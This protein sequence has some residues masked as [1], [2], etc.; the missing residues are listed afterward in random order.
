MKKI[1]LLIAV[2]LPIVT[3]AQPRGGFGGPQGGPQGNPQVA[4]AKEALAKAKADSENAKKATKANTW[5]KLYDAAMAAYELPIANLIEGATREQISLYLK[6]QRVLSSGET[7]NGAEGVYSVDTYAD[8]KLYYTP[9]GTLAFWIANQVDENALD[10]AY[11]AIIKSA[12]LN[13]KGKDLVKKVQKINTAYNTEATFQYLYGDYAKATELFEKATNSTKNPVLNGIDSLATYYTGVMASL[14]G[15]NQKAIKFLTECANIGYTNN[16]SL[17]PNLANVYV[18]LGDKEAAK[19]TLED[20]FI[21]YPENQGIL[22]GLINFYVESGSDTDKLFDLL[23]TAQANEPNN[24]SLF[25][26]EGDI[27]KKLGNKEEAAKFFHKA[28]EVDPN[29]VY[30]IL[31]VGILYYEEAVEIQAKAAEEVDDAKYAV[32]MDEFN[33]NLKQAIDPLE[34]SFA[35]AQE[36]DVKMAIAEYLKNIYFRYR[37]ESPEYMAAYEKYN[38]FIKGE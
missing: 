29:Y 8:K 37:T 31:N 33:A 28:T 26:V 7:Y 35:L 38:N 24:P 1:L 25:Y 4:A 21:K 23:H 2:A 6:G 11:T 22:V 16:G 14:A 19:K 13:P 36:Q 32:L 17:Y 5:D 15:D 30:G 27:Y 3:F 10:L 18:A 9:E 12:E 34:K 20:G